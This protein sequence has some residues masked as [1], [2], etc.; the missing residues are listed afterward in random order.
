MHAHEIALRAG[1]RRGGA[2][3]IVQPGLEPFGG[4][5]GLAHEMVGA[6]GGF[7]GEIGAGIGGALDLDRGSQFG[8]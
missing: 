3:G 2:L 1:W 5:C 4:G 6:V 8:A 7:L